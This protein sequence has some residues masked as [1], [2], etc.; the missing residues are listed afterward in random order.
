[1]N[2]LRRRFKLMDRRNDVFRVKDPLGGQDKL[3]LLTRDNT[4]RYAFFVS[5]G[6]GKLV[7]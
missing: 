1:M 3:R 4:V 7:K 6:I 5:H 2:S